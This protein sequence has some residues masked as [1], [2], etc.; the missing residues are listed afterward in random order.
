M[1]HSGRLNRNKE[2][3]QEK[4]IQ[5]LCESLVQITKVPSV[6]KK[7]NQYNFYG[8]RYLFPSFLSGA[9]RSN[10]D[11]ICEENSP[12]RKLNPFRMLYGLNAKCISS[13]TR[14]LH[15]FSL[16]F[17]QP[18]NDFSNRPKYAVLKL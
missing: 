11:T 12:T 13:Y 6:N 18:E 10:K 17:Y 5:A 14:F 4:S 8:Q 15:N 2:I 9:S 1:R 7:L 16:V 3:S